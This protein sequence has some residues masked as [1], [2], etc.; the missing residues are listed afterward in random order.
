VPTFYYRYNDDLFDDEQPF[1]STAKS[2][3]RFIRKLDPDFDQIGL[4]RYSST[5]PARRFLLF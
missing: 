1:A 4:I 5:A 2:A 3:L